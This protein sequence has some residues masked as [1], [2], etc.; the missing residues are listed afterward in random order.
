MSLSVNEELFIV[1][2]SDFLMALDKCRKDELIRNEQSETN[3][4]NHNSMSQINSWSLNYEFV[5]NRGDIYVLYP[6]IMVWLTK[7]DSYNCLKIMKYIFNQLES[8]DDNG[9]KSIDQFITSIVNQIVES[10]NM[11]MNKLNDAV[12]IRILLQNSLKILGLHEHNEQ[13]NEYKVSAPEARKMRYKITINDIKYYQNGCESD[14]MSKKFYSI[15]IYL[16]RSNIVNT[17]YVKIDQQISSVEWDTW[18]EI[19][20][21]LL[22][23]FLEFRIFNA[24]QE[25]FYKGRLEDSNDKRGDAE[26]NHTRTSNPFEISSKSKS[27]TDSENQ[28]KVSEELNNDSQSC[29][30]TKNNLR[31][32]EPDPDKYYV[33]SEEIQVEF[34]SSP[35]KLWVPARHDTKSQPLVKNSNNR[36]FMSQNVYQSVKSPIKEVTEEDDTSLNEHFFDSNK[37]SS[38][39]NFAAA[40]EDKDSKDL[41]SLDQID[42]EI[43]NFYL[44][45]TVCIGPD[46]DNT[47]N[48]LRKSPEVVTPKFELSNESSCNFFDFTK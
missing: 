30:L 7:R 17:D 47:L 5:Q 12:I 36:K 25:W 14:E 26:T 13:V 2:K 38:K 27:G 45:F 42:E 34:A 22:W 19:E 37:L 43:S 21:N 9:R 1:L 6:D 3:P 35:K 15:D 11:Y 41:V 28:Q 32:S 20:A 48:D 18:F 40:E 4:Q 24:D 39:F 31:N 44:L 10:Y 46:K 29:N 16:Q 8:V 33:N 23:E